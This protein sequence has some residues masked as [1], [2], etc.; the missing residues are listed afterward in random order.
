MSKVKSPT[1]VAFAFHRPI[2]SKREPPWEVTAAS[3]LESVAFPFDGKE[4]WDRLT[5]IHR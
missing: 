3:S 2:G 1:S 5:P 4:Q